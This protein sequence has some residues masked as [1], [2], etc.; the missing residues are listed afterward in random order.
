[1]LYSEAED[2]Y[3]ASGNVVIQRND[4]SLSADFVRIDRKNRIAFAEGEVRLQTSQDYLTGSRMVLDLEDQ[5]GTV[6]DGLVYIEE[7]NFYIRGKKIEKTGVATYRIEDASFT[8]CDGEKPD[9]QVTGADLSVRVGGYGTLKHAALWAGG[10]PVGYFPYFVFPVKRNRQSGLLTPEIGYSD[11]N[12]FEWIQP[13]FWTISR[14]MDATFYYH[15]IARRGEKGGIE[16]RYAA[17]A[18]SKGTLMADY[19]KDSRIDGPGSADDRWGYAGDAYPRPNNERFWLRMKADQDLPAGARA[20]LDIDIVSDQDYLREFDEGAAGYDETNSYY[21]SAFGRGL[22]R[23]FDPVRTNRLNLRKTGATYSANTDLRWYEDTRKGIGDTDS[24]TLGRLP[25]IS[26][27]TLRQ[28]IGGYPLLFQADTEYSYFHRE[29]GASGHRTVLH[30]R[31]FLPLPLGP[32]LF[33]QPSAGSRQTSWYV[34]ERENAA[35]SGSHVRHRSAWDIRADLSTDIARIYHSPKIE[36]KAVKHT[37]IPELSYIYLSEND[38]EKYPDLDGFET[39]PSGHRLALSLTQLLT[40]KTKTR[41]PGEGLGASREETRY[42]RFFRF[43]IE[44]AYDFDHE[45]RAGKDPFPPLYLELDYTPLQPFR[46]RAESRWDH[47]E[48]ALLTQR[49]SA[50]LRNRRNDHL[51]VEY[52]YYRD[53]RHSL[54]LRASVGVTRRIRLSGNYERNLEDETDIEKGVECLYRA[55]CWSVALSYSDDQTDRRVSG[56]IRLHGLGGLGDRL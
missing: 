54:D 6:T 56:M 2:T 33:F 8:T 31:L 35:P 15:H 29:E 3:E 21:E 30:P 1:V 43:R 53:L 39:F 52:R 4:T 49:L 11:R 28:Y 22:D 19:L 24:D 51:A 9:W 26:F 5:T 27:D 42:N 40:A 20:R 7:R 50:R 36:K 16:A 55:Q 13:Y 46:I 25:V 34:K 18:G 41:T 38:E 12:G 47:Q 44:Q 17:S 23:P 10:L 45:K 37:L 48:G 32:Y 14:S